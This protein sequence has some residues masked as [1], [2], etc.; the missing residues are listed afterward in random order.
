MISRNDGKRESPSSRSF[1]FYEIVA[2]IENFIFL[3]RFY[4][5]LLR[6]SASA[7]SLRQKLQDEQGKR[8][9]RCRPPRPTIGRIFAT[10]IFIAGIRASISAAMGVRWEK[11]TPAEVN[12]AP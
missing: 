5:I 8:E 9:R 11:N 6:R 4:P 10:G 1:Y 3:S 12:Y 7:A 2:A